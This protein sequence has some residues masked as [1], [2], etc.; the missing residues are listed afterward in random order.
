MFGRIAAAQ[1][2]HVTARKRLQESLELSRE[3]AISRGVVWALYFLAQ[4]ALSQG[5]PSRAR[6]TFAES[7]RLARQTGDH[8]ATAS[9]IEGFAGALAVTQPGR[10][11]RLA[12]AA[13]A[14]R[15]ALASTPY[16]ADR[17]RLNRWLEVAA[18]GLGDAATAVAEKEGRAMT[19]DQAVAYALTADER[20]TTADVRRRMTGRTFAGLTRREV[21]VLRL[22]ALAQSN[23]EI[24]NALV[25]SEKT[26]ERH[27]SH[28]FAKLQV[29]SRTGAVR[30]A[31]QA[32][33]A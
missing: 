24:A 15:E 12:A 14:L 26:V 20:H 28:I 11:V 31:V 32:G 16:P 9:C 3:L 7:L 22:V 25:L 6:T 29:T 18:R 23:R 17:E 4:H 27:L 5:D 1:E 33:I 19:L 13:N 2:D 30:I 8:L 10:S 21:E